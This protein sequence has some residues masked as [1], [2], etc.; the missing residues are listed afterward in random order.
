MWR[1]YCNITG[2]VRQFALSSHPTTKDNRKMRP[3][4]LTATKYIY[5]VRR[6]YWIELG[7]PPLLFRKRVWRKSIALCLLC[8]YMYSYYTAVQ[9]TGANVGE[10][11]NFLRNIV[12]VFKVFIYCTV[13]W[14]AH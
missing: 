9:P 10:C 11:E 8:A 1:K 4:T 14:F 7:P 5:T 13:F 12:K 6:V 3:L 2:Y